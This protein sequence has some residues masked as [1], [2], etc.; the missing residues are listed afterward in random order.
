[1][2]KLF[3]LT[4]A[5]G[6]FVAAFDP[7][8][9]YYIEIPFESHEQL[10]ELNDAGWS[11]GGVNF[12]S[13]RISLVVAEENLFNLRDMK[14]LS[15]QA[16]AFA[17]DSQFKTYEEINTIFHEI[18]DN[19]PQLASV[20][21]IG[22]TLEGKDLIAMH[23]TSRFVRPESGEK[24]AVLFDAM[25]HAREVMTPE[26]AIDIADY[27][28]KNYGIDEKVSHWVNNYS[29][30]IVPMVNP[31]GN[32]KVWNAQSMWRK[33]TRDGHGVDVNRNYDYAWNACNGSSGNKNSDT[34]RGASAGSEPETQ[35]LMQ[36]AER[37]KP[38]INIS[39]HSY[40]E[41]VIYPYG[42]S[43]K[44]VPAPD[45]PIYER[46]GKELAATLVRDSGNGKYTAGTA[47]E[48]LYDVDG[49]SIDH[50]YAKHKTLAYVIEMNSTNQ[51]F[52]P[53]FSQW[54]EKTVERQRAGWMYI[55]D[56]M[57]KP[58]IRP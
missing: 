19:Y 56:Q 17:P 21:V 52:Q 8:R 45:G 26:V 9:E 29:I 30:W 48:L 47:Y 34:Y 31:D 55:L 43:P 53:S 3:L 27:L 15:R 54:R 12:E 44:R 40:S 42:C 2:W 7:P 23:L 4:L 51:G 13:K 39:Y 20:E 24:P 11:I 22:K 18:A 28:T 37:I 58:G 35:V 25:H 50:M 38:V 46:I 57:G 16:I 10:K 14:V 6:V 36:L 32:D 33:N 41:I 49:G 5:V 1:M